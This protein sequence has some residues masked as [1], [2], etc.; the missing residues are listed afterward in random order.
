ME[1]STTI[2]VHNHEARVHNLGLGR[3]TKLEGGRVIQNENQEI[4]LM[5]GW[6][7]V[8][9]KLWEEAKRNPIVALHIKSGALEEKALSPEEIKSLTEDEAHRFIVETWDESMLKRMRA[10]ESR[11]TV[12]A[13]INEQIAKLEPSAESVAAAKAKTEAIKLGKR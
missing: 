6:N 1:P 2:L 10:V 13:A 7:P 12:L 3:Q 5:P 9:S 8:D 4:T 11:G